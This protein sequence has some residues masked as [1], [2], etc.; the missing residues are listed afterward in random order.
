MPS[1]TSLAFLF[2]FSLF[3]SWSCS[4]ITNG[5]AAGIAPTCQQLLNEQDCRNTQIQGTCCIWCSGNAVPNCVPAY[6][7]YALGEETCGDTCLGENGNCDNNA[8]CPGSYG[9]IVDLTPG[10]FSPTPGRW[11]FTLNSGNTV[12]NCPTNGV[13]DFSFSGT[14]GGSGTYT[15]RAEEGTT[16]PLTSIASIDAYGN[17]VSG[18]CT[19]SA[20]EFQIN[21]NCPISLNTL[22]SAGFC[23]Y[24]M[25]RASASTLAFSFLFLLV[26]SLLLL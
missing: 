21:V 15:V 26:A 5:Q 4:I 9:Q 12:F 18:G 13:I 16:N 8:H 19:G 7:S 17:F 11:S 6:N 1:T 20:N 24:T 10:G 23:S 2:L 25:V 14:S 22:S 3:I